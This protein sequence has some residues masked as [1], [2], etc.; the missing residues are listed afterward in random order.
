[1]YLLIPFQAMGGMNITTTRLPGAVSGVLTVLLIYFVGR[2]LFDQQTGLMAALLLALNPWHIQQSRWGHEASINALLGLVPLAMLLWA[3]TP[4]M[5]DKNCNSKPI[6]AI[7]AGTITGI[8]CYG[9]H[10]VRIFVPVFLLAAGLVTIAGWWRQIKIRKGAIVIGAYILGL[11]L[12]FGPL[13][14]QHLFHPEG[15]SRHSP[16]QKSLIAGQPILTGLKNVGW[17][18]IQHFGPDFLFIHGDIFEIQRLPGSGEFLWYMLPLMLA[19]LCLVI[20]KFRHSYAARVLLVFVLAYPVGDSLY[21]AHSIHALRSSPGL[22]SLIL[23]GAF[24]LVGGFRALMKKRRMVGAGTVIVFT[25]IFIISNARFLHRF[26]FEYN[27]QPEIYNA[28]HA[29]LVEACEWLK[30]VF[31]NEN[32]GAILISSTDMLMAYIDTLV[33]LNYDPQRWFS[34][35]KNFVTSGEYDYFT[36]YGKMYFLYSVDAIRAVLANLPQFNLQGD[37]IFIVRPGELPLKNPVYEIRNPEGQATLEIY[38]LKTG[39]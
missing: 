21:T 9:Y 33:C 14:W 6:R 27:R 13:V 5:C 38:R 17:R 1:M 16:F 39:K 18:Y 15:I 12:T 8:C 11:G 29:D 30:P 25:V 34:D 3:N 20:W 2:R 10:S 24:G 23:L 32:I 4:I 35:T 37:V 28:Y 26:Y 36:S 31:Y 19:G 22:C 7:F